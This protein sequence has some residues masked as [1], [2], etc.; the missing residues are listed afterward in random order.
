MTLVELKLI[1]SVIVSSV[2]L[3]TDEAIRIVMR[4][5]KLKELDPRKG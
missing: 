2:A 5:I 3:D 4:E 1:L